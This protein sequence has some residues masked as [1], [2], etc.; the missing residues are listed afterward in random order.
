MNTRVKQSIIQFAL[1]APDVEV[2]GFI[3][4]TDGGVHAYPCPNVTKDEEGTAR[5]FE[6][7]PDAYTEAAR[8]G[9][10]CAIYHSHSRGGAHGFSEE[11]LGLA[12]EMCLPLHLYVVD[13]GEWL[14]YTPPTYVV[15]L[16]GQSFAWGEADCYELVR[17][18]YRQ[19]RG[20]YL[21]DYE[22]DETFE[23]AASSAIT[24]YIASEGFSPVPIGD[25]GPREG[26]V[27]LFTTPGSSYPHHLAI[28]IGQQR[29]LHHPLGGL[30]RTDQL[31]GK[32]LKRLSQVL[33]YTG[34]TTV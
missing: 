17:T 2:C 29:M 18:Y 5:T 8:L 7:S 10:I 28:Y 31:D 24:Q 22:R 19:E 32:G 27:L 30:S 9:R 15:P 4:Q 13:T 34:P 23:R 12:Q 14:S 33:R 26:D 11:D 3:Y 21:T 16:T 1:A 25:A 20:V 6:I